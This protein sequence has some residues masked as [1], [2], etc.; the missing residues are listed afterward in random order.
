MYSSPTLGFSVLELGATSG[1]Y[2]DFKTPYSDD[3]DHR[4]IAD[5][6]GLTIYA[7]SSTTSPNVLNIISGNVNI[8]S[9]TFFVDYLANEVGIGTTTP[10]A[11]LDVA[12]NMLITYTGTTDALRIT[13]L[14]TGN[15]FVVYDTTNDTSPFVI[16]GTGDVIIGS[17]AAY[18]GVGATPTLQ[19]HAN[20]TLAGK[21][22]MSATYWGQA[23]T[24]NPALELM[25][26]G[27]TSSQPIGT[28]V[29]V[30]SNESLGTIRWGAS[31]GS[32][33][34]PAASI[35]GEIDG[36][37]SATSVPTRL[38]FNTNSGGTAVSEKMRIQASGNVG[39]GITA[40]TS[41]LH[42]GG[43]ANIT[44]TLR[45][46]GSAAIEGTGG[47]GGQLVLGWNN[48]TGITGQQN[49][50][51]NFDVDNAN[52]ARIFFQNS[53]GG[54]AI[55]LSIESANAN[56]GLGITGT[57]TAKLH[58]GENVRFTSNIYDTPVVS[59]TASSTF[60]DN[61]AGK[62]LVVDSTSAVTV[63]FAPATYSGFTVTVIR[64]N[65]GNVTIANSS[66]I[67]RLNTAN[68]LTS[69]ISGRY[70]TASVVYTAT[71]EL[72]LIGDIL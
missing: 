19:L 46:V 43:T 39:I 41:K 51:W 30:A 24:Q 11:N 66:T 52:N 70:L 15:S 10:A 12:G 23:L 42:V 44:G 60:A 22:R 27:G 54:T 6:G 56:V 65:T 71:N 5:S 55:G 29:L 32:F 53:S 64:K 2:I 8:D 3:Y 72:I 13:Q 7:G 31:N 57:A 48:V 14:G 35:E 37:P 58:V 25:K 4:I 36:T 26:S 28:H 20:S 63:T 47:E 21:A 68:Y 59:V 17:G 33:F 50:T 69:N 38:I 18:Q 61:A 62:V 67:T 49:G 16:D 45:A 40:P 9:G 34:S 1:N